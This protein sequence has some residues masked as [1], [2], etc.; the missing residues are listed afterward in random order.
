[1]HFN[2]P[3]VPPRASRSRLGAT[4]L[5]LHR[6]LEG[7]RQREQVAFDL[8]EAWQAR[9]AD[10]RELIARRLDCLDRELADLSSSDI[11]SPHLSL[12]AMCDTQDDEMG[13]AVTDE[14]EESAMIF[15]TI[16]SSS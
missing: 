4:L 16:S 10:H 5:R 7:S 3:S 13:L 2:Q 11:P 1:M 14:N 9:W 12:V 15:R 6:N 8:F